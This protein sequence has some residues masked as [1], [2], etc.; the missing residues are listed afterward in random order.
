MAA[1]RYHPVLAGLHWLL[2][3]L[4]I[5][6]LAGGALSLKVVSNATPEKLDLLRIHMLMGATVLVLMLIRLVVR[7]TTEHPPL[8]S[9]G[10][11]VLDR[12]ATWMHWLLYALVFAMVGS[13]VGIAVLAGLP[14][15][16]FFGHGS[17][18]VDFR[19]FPPRLAHGILS[20][21][22]LLMIALHAAAALYHQFFKRDGLL[23][24]MWWGA[25]Y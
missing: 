7:L 23:S 10:N 2:T 21:L 24:R 13:G 3:L 18:P 1:K 14:D 25:R 11:A 6:L 20:K 9:T 17:L 8:A 19:A 5:A 16:V 15:I 12:L 22:L 4:L